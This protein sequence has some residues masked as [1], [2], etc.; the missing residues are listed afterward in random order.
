M[1]REP[2]RHSLAVA[3]ALLLGSLGQ[4][5]TA[6][7]AGAP[8]ADGKA[9]PE[10]RHLDQRPSGSST[11]TYYLDSRD[12]GTLNVLTSAP[13]LPLGLTSGGLSTYTPTRTAAV[14]DST[15]HGTSPNT[16]YAARWDSAAWA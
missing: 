10:R 12:Y 8:V 3:C 5:A 15:R 2:P 11:L 16:V 4:G 14:D 1:R 13:D 9:P 6:R 7:A